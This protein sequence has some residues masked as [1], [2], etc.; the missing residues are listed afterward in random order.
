MADEKILIVWENIPDDTFL[1]VVDADSDVGRLA[2]K[3]PGK[4]I[5]VDEGDEKNINALYEILNEMGH[6]NIDAV[7]DGPFSKVVVCG[8]IL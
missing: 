3:C 7:L 5:N 1:Y 8:F 6:T 4:F 2:L